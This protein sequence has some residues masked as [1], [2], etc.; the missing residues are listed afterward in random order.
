MDYDTTGGFGG[1][2]PLFALQ[3]YMPNILHQVGGVEI[4]FDADEILLD[5]PSRDEPIENCHAPSFI[6]RATGACTTERLLADDSACALLV[7]VHVARGVAELVRRMH[8]GFTL[9]SEAA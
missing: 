1:L 8:E 6:V 5:A 3:I 9:L 7:E 4:V 2:V